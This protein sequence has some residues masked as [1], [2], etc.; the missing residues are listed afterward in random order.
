MLVRCL[1]ATTTNWVCTQLSASGA[2]TAV[3]AA[4]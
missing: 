1:C 4:A 3:A 2:E